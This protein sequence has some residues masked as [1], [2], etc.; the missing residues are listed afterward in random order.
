MLTP[1]N[2]PQLDVVM[3]SRESRD[4]IITS[5]HKHNVK[6][7][8]E[9]DACD[10]TSRISLNYLTDFIAQTYTIEKVKSH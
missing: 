1:C 4:K 2:N 7:D 9:T 5:I 10:W 6:L 8:S 3:R